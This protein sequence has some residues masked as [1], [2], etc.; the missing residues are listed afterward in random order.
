MTQWEYMSVL[1]TRYDLATRLREP[2]EQG[3][4]LVSVV[5]YFDG[6]SVIAYLKRQL[7]VRTEMHAQ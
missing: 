3:W 4:E 6:D 5:N 7:P 1:W 2:G